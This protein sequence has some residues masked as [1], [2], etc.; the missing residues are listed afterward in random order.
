MAVYQDRRELNEVEVD[1]LL[2]AWPTSDVDGETAA[3]HADLVAEAD[4]DLRP[5]EVRAAIAASPKLTEA[6][7]AVAND[8]IS[9]R[10]CIVT[11]PADTKTDG[12]WATTYESLAKSFVESHNATLIESP[13]D[14]GSPSEPPDPEDAEDEE[15]PEVTVTSK[16]GNWRL[17][18]RYDR[19]LGVTGYLSQI[20]AKL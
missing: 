3:T 9:P 17:R 5:D 4:F 1:A 20:E 11:M 18:D 2:S 19:W 8:A 10:W 13:V 15:P 12:V 14:E 7:I 16:S 6:G